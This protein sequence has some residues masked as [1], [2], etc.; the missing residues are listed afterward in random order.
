MFI[1][2][3]FRQNF[4]A[5]AK[6]E[7]VNIIL[8]HDD[9]IDGFMSMYVLR[10]SFE[11]IN[12]KVVCIPVMYGFEP[13]YKQINDLS[14]KHKKVNLVVADFCY[15]KDQLLAISPYVD[16]LSVLDHH[17]TAAE[18]HGGYGYKCISNKCRCSDISV[19]II[20]SQSGASL[21]YDYVSKF[22][23]VPPIVYEFVLGVEDHDLWNYVFDKTEAI[24][25][26]LVGLP[27][28]YEAWYDFFH[29]EKSIINEQLEVAKLKVEYRRKAVKSI[30][31]KATLVSFEGHTVPFVNSSHD[32]SSYVGQE[33][34]KDYPF[35]FMFEIIGNSSI[36][37][38][39]LNCVRVSLRSDR[40]TGMDLTS[41]AK[42]YKGGGHKHAAGFYLDI[43]QFTEII[44]TSI[45]KN[46][47]NI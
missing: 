31:E 28:T 19:K 12:Q 42:K 13:P 37:D 4:D 11:K 7:A 6:A 17:D 41:I 10:S 25:E 21:A 23:M 29:Q 20:E 39:K 9:C 27:R 44:K 15:S 22:T 47:Q 26:L 34:Y 45:Y 14:L 3:F 38:C 18:L 32:Y 8:Y 36:R 1:S 24:I 16:I 43:Y 5:R 35:A 33:L 30:C 40:K 46:L 2:H